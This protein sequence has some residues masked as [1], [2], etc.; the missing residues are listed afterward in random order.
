MECSECKVD[1]NKVMKN[2]N[3]LMIICFFAW[4]FGAI[5]WI[6]YYFK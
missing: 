6:L 2:L 1:K 5:G 3:W 4:F